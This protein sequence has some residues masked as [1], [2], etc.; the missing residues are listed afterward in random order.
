MPQNSNNN[1]TGEN[2][3]PVLFNHDFIDSLIYPAGIISRKGIIEHA[4]R[5]FIDIFGLEKDLGM[6]N[7]PAFFSTDCKKIVARAFINSL[8]G[9][10]TSSAVELKLAE[11]SD[12]NNTPVEI[13]MQPLMNEGNVS[14]VLVFIKNSDK[15]N[16]TDNYSADNTSD[17]YGDSHYFEFSPLP[18]IRF[19]RNMTVYMC[20]RSFEGV[21][22]YKCEEISN[23]DT[24][25][26]KSLFKY[27]AEKIKNYIT[28]II[29]G[30][31]PFKRIGEIKIRTKNDDERVVNVII[32][33]VSNNNEITAI[34][35]LME[36]ITMLKDLKYRLSIAK[37]INLLSDIGRGFIHSINNTTNVI[38]NQTQLL[39]I[40]TEKKSVLDGLKQV[41][42]YV[43][44]VI[45]HIRRIQNFLDEREEGEIERKESL[46]KIINDSVEFV[47]IH[48][49]VE[50]NRKRRGITI[51]RN[52]DNNLNIKT[53]TR[54]L[55]ELIIWGVLRVSAYVEK[56][57]TISIELN[58]NE[59]Y[60]LSISVEKS[61]VSDKENIVPFTIDGFSP[62]EIRN[63]AEKINVKIIEEESGDRYSIKIIFPKNSILEDEEILNI[64][65]DY[66]IRDKDILIVEDEKAL[67]LILGNLFER[68][69]NRVFITDNGCKAFE[70]FKTKDYD[71]VISDYDVSG[72]TG[73]ELAARV[74]EINENTLTV[75]LSGWS[76]GDLKVYDRLVDFYIAKPFN[77]DDLLKGIATAMPLKKV[78]NNS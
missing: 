9:A 14:S 24:Q 12:Q 16:K 76:L 10:F 59:F 42:K 28:E 26:V 78:G 62:S 60:S 68:M 66:S 37:R 73:I 64:N 74:K 69:G 6:F 54:F 61:V 65:R 55:R 15:N 2:N 27:D 11:N 43:H 45:E 51:E 25:V 32:Y 58:K 31:I 4:N 63:A 46:S 22:G 39:Q 57:G 8:N 33:P 18:L 35:L 5:P 36:D 50:E 3:S 71:M 41:E 29:N 34:D 17:D 53:D 56:K 70:E 13:L 23:P 20:S 52:Y 40:I 75:L 72:L 1:R 48:F 30:N 19:N 21:V 44:D 7:W 67:Q 38:L 47:K 77:I 49:K